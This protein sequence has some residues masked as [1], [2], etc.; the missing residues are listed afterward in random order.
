MFAQNILK[1]IAILQAAGVLPQFDQL[2]RR[3]K[4]IIY[5]V[6]IGLIL[7]VALLLAAAVLVVTFIFK[8]TF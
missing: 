6:G 2:G 5:G 7:F 3:G 8:A 4:R 1:L